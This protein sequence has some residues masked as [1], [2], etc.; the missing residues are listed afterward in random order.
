MEC[1]SAEQVAAYLRG[2]GD[3]R[4][5]ESHARDCPACAMQLLLGRETLQ[6][7]RARVSRPATD[8]LR[9]PKR[10]AAPWIPW[11]AAAAVALVA[12]LA[13]ALRPSTLPEGPVVKHEPP[14]PKP[15]LVKE[16][17]K[18]IEEPKRPELPSPLPEPPA[19]KPEPRPEPKPEPP[20]LK[21]EPR[22]EPKPEPPAPKVEPKPEPKKP[23]PATVV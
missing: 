11:A 22:P 1:L 16:P 20:A 5:V 23:A 17:E 21:P 10:R 7:L 13:F 9:V 4:P 19:P 12:I 18:K 6:E 14:A 3:A 15:P 8:R 2:R